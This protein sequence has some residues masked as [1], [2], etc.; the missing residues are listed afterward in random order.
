MAINRYKASLIA[1]ILIILLIPLGFTRSNNAPSLTDSAPVTA[2]LAGSIIMNSQAMT[3]LKTLTE[4]VGPRLSGSAA[5]YQAAEWALAQFQ[6]AGLKNAHIETFTMTGWERGWAK[7]RIITP[8]ARPLHIESLGW[9][10]STPPGGVKGEVVI[11]KDISEA[12]LR[13]QA[14]KLRDKIVFLDTKSL[15]AEGRIS[16]YRHLHD[17]YPVFK[18]LGILAVLM[19]D[20]ENF[21]LLNAHKADLGISIPPVPVAQIGKEDS[22]LIAELLEKQ[23]VTV[24]FEY[25]NRTPGE[26]KVANVIAELPGREDSGEWVL[27]GAHLDSWDYGTG[28]QDNGT[29]SVAILDAARALASLGQPPRR[30]IRFALWGGEEQGL[31]GSKAYVHAHQAELDKC[32]A[33]LNTDNGGGHPYGWKVEGRDDLAEAMKPISNSLINLGGNQISKEFTFDTDH[34]YFAL[35]GIPSL[36]LLVDMTHYDE[37]HHKSSDTLDKVEAHNLADATAIVAVTGYR[38][39]DAPERL[40]PRLERAKVEEMIK[41]ANFYDILKLTGEW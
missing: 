30:T 29:G 20:R 39:A 1:L 27:M 19:P 12:Y 18:E 40:A 8:T 33:T 25:Q 4:Q 23:A 5:H 38:I 6:K 32:V 37:I 11:L 7:G 21:N 34:F 24:E 28:A 13:S 9:T 31:L 35:A 3:Y 15:F 17:A 10:I 16:G 2:Q 36:D 14:G 41:K 22:L 26:I